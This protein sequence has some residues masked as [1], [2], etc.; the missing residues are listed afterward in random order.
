ML[1]TSISSEHRSIRR[2]LGRWIALGFIVAIGLLTAAAVAQERR[3]VLAIG[4]ANGESLLAHLSGMPELRNDHATAAAHVARLDGT[5][6]AAGI[7]LELAPPSARASSGV[8]ASRTLA[9]ADGTFELRYATD[10]PW[11][12]ALMR[13]A[14]LFHLLLG[15][16]ALTVLLAGTERILRSRLVEPLRQFAHQVRFMC[17]GGGWKP[18]LPPSDAELTELA[19]P[20]T[21]AGTS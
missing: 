5:L 9:L 17:S 11:M 19:P 2:R 14:L 16:A 8:L 4:K 1:R 7:R 3:L 13:R 18:L 20:R 10:A 6:R 21:A 12:A 15:G